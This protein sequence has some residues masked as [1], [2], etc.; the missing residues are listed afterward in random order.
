MSSRNAKNS[1]PVK[2]KTLRT[3]FLLFVTTI[4]FAC[5]T[6]ETNSSHAADLKQLQGVWTVI[7]ASEDGKPIP[8][9]IGSRFHFVHDRLTIEMSGRSLCALVKILPSQSLGRISLEP[10]PPKEGCTSQ[11]NAYE[12]AG[13]TFTLIQAAPPKVPTDMSDNGQQKLILKRTPQ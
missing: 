8:L 13:D 5:H 3:A 9:L 2:M 10:D 7:S 4:L 12:L 1:I 6:R 11:N